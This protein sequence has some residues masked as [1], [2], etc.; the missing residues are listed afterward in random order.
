[1]KRVLHVVGGMDRGGAETMIMNLYRAIDRSQIQFDI[2]CMQDGKHHYD[3][4]IERMGGRIFHIKPPRERGVIRHINDIRSVLL[5][6]GPYDVVHGHTNF[7]TGLIA[8]ASKLSD[9]NIR[10][11]HSHNTSESNNNKLIRKIYFE[12]MKYLIRKNSTK[13]IAC[14]IKELN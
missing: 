10:I 11:C 12:F 7:H 5:K 4:E 6:N 9:V 14:G 1:M 13:M 8:I 3:E 2:L